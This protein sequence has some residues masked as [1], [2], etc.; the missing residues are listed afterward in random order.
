MRG[1]ADR[2]WSRLASNPVLS[3]K[4]RFLVPTGRLT[5]LQA[6]GFASRSAAQSVCNTLRRTGQP[7]LV[8]R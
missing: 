3:G 6:G 4:S 8:T 2:L 7:C 5:K 1:N